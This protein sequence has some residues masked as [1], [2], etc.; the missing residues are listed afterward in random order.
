MR[1]FSMN[2]ILKSKSNTNVIEIITET[3]P[4]DKGIGFESKQRH[5]RPTKVIINTSL[6]KE[7]IIEVET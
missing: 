3:L 7:H 1:C 5:L 4:T 6:L 2:S